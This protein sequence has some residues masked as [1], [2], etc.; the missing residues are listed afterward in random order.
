MSTTR[1]EWWEHLNTEH[2][3][4]WF[5]IFGSW[6]INLDSRDQWKTVPVLSFLVY[7]GHSMFLVHLFQ[8]LFSF[9]SWFLLL[10]L[11]VCF[12]H[13][14]SVSWAMLS[15]TGLAKGSLSE[16]CTGQGLLRLNMQHSTSSGWLMMTD[17]Y[18]WWLMVN[19]I[20]EREHGMWRHACVSWICFQSSHFLKMWCAVE[21]L[22]MCSSCAC[23]TLFHL[24]YFLLSFF[25]L[26]CKASQTTLGTTISVKQRI[27]K[28]F[29]SMCSDRE[30]IRHF[31]RRGFAFVQFHSVEE[32]LQFKWSQ[33]L[34]DWN[35]RTS[36]SHGCW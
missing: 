8:S 20:Y 29:V 31:S 27:Y 7:F 18:W 26:W 2:Q 36:M 13:V 32:R 30:D 9:H 35:P 3:W 25:L 5:E 19:R 17:D 28:S 16:L 23:F 34:S 14:A 11:L 33:K 24:K 1:E 15:C 22:E 10:S 6:S 12:T 4:T 21:H